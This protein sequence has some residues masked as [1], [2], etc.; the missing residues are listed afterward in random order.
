MS[1]QK[2]KGKEGGPTLSFIPPSSSSFSS[3]LLSFPPPPSASFFQV[4]TKEKKVGDALSLSFHYLECGSR[5]L[6][7]RHHPF[8]PT[9]YVS[10]GNDCGRPRNTSGS[11]SIQ[12][13]RRCTLLRK[14]PPGNI[15]SRETT[16]RKTD[17]GGSNVNPPVS[18]DDSSPFQFHP[19]KGVLG[20]RK[21]EARVLSFPGHFG[22]KVGG[23]VVFLLS[24][25]TIATVQTATFLPSRHHSSHFSFQFRVSRSGCMRG[26]APRKTGLI[27]TGLWGGETPP[28]P[29]AEASLSS[30]TCPTSTCSVPPQAEEEEEEEEEEK[31]GDVGDNLS[32]AAT[33]EG[34]RRGSVAKAPV[35]R[36]EGGGE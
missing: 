26:G 27:K 22:K 29:C 12:T 30:S 25:T 3:A 11:L 4:R 17:A 24:T 15:V 10:V 21:T 5:L 2:R 6:C 14:P 7:Q 13:L 16:A 36:G 31:E 1:A 8:V 20:Q 35:Q 9:C 23:A 28:I 18:L 19:I 33:T 34:R 32:R